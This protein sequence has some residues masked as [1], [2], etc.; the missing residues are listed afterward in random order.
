MGASI[1][2]QCHIVFLPTPQDFG[3]LHPRSA[4]IIISWKVAGMLV[5]PLSAPLQRISLLDT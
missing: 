1:C 2:V 5:N 3:I 4:T